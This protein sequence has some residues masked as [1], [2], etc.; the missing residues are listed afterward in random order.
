M[1]V[2]KT[3]WTIGVSCGLLALGAFCAQAGSGE[4]SSASGNKA[5]LAEPDTVLVDRLD[6]TFQHRFQSTEGNIFGLSRIP[7]TPD[8]RLVVHWKPGEKLEKEVAE[9][10]RRGG[11]SGAF[12]LAKPWVMAA[13]DK[14]ALSKAVVSGHASVD[15]APSSGRRG[16]SR[17]II[18]SEG[19]VG[20]PLPSQRQVTAGLK[21]ATAAFSKGDRHDFDAGKWRV[22]S[23]P[24]RATQDC[25]DCHQRLTGDKALAVGSV[26]GVAMYA[27]TRDGVSQA[28]APAQP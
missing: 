15:D 27:F 20:A 6:Y 4:E 3:G 24:I 17:P 26:L 12:L 23:R 13:V 16:I 7:V 28:A 18:L 1:N 21:G 5:T 11:W 25:L 14:D 10:L 8:H 19:E 9:D 22:L 2:G